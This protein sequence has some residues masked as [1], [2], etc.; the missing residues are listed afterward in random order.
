[1]STVI[2]IASD[3]PGITGISRL[4]IFGDSYSSVGYDVV[5]VDTA[6]HALQ[7]LGVPFPG[8]TWN[9]EDLPNWVG[10]FITKYCPPPRYIPGDN[11]QDEKYLESPLLVYDYAKG[12]DRIP[13][14]R[15]QIQDRFLPHVG[16][17]PSWAPWASNDSL[18]ITWVGINDCA[19][20]Q[21]HVANIQSLFSLQE[22][23]YN[24]GARNFLFIDVPP[25]HKSPVGSRIRSTSFDN[26][27]RELLSATR[28]FAAAHPDVTAMIFSAS[29]TFHSILDEPQL[30]GF[31][32]S[33][34]KKFGG[35]I[36][37]D[38]IHPTSKVHDYV[39]NAVAEFLD[40]VEKYQKA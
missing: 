3:W 2:Q 27:N 5:P 38:H 33:D 14:V 21:E 26:F 39:A 35:S 30:Y 23:L 11:E 12:G 36:W 8:F 15:R 25:I 20:S 6:P 18:F 10:H 31:P 37:V 17:K 9:E 1:M 4:M 28:E 7:P 19:Y 24:A 22:E 34:S 32:A 16:T 13:G 29:A 40:S